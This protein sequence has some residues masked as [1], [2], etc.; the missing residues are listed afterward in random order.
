MPDAPGAGKVH[1]EIEA[2]RPLPSERRLVSV[3]FVDR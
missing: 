1:G 3:L 2:E